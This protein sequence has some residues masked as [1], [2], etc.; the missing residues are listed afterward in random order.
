MVSEKKMGPIMAVAFITHHTPTITS[1]MALGG[2]MWD[3]LKTVACYSKSY[4]LR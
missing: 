3:F 1:C 4:P 2:L